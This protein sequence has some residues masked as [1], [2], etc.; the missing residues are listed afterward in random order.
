MRAKMTWEA[1]GSISE[2]I[3]ACAV[4]TSLLYLAAQVR[5]GAA[6]VRSQII[7]SL[8]NNEIEIVSKPAVDTVLA[9]AIQKAHTGGK[10][11]EEEKAQYTMW[12]FAHLINHQQ[13]KMEYDRLGVDSGL[14]QSQRVRLAGMMQPPLAQAVFRKIGDR[15]TGEYREYV[16]DTFAGKNGT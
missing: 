14:Y 4:I 6:D 15:F 10:L 3:G 12:V 7:H 13:I 2:F 5:Q 11:S 8:H 16:E 1:F 9:L